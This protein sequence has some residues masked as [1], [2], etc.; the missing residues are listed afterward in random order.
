MAVGREVIAP[1]AAS[2]ADLYGIWLAA[3]PIVVWGA[4]LG[5]WFASLL[6]EKALIR[7]VALLAIAELVSTLVFLDKL[8]TDI[9]LALFGL[10]GLCGALIGTLWGGARR[11]SEM[12]GFEGDSG[13]AVDSSSATI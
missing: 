8:R 3:G 9:G 6:P 12:F 1:I 11:G 7:F 4:P 13:L 2:K 10:V 5:S